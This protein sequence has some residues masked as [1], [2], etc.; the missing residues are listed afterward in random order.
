MI[1]YVL[2][3]VLDIS[4]KRII[5]VK[6]QKPDFLKGKINLV[7]GK[8]EKDESPYDAAIREL[9][10]ETGII[11][12][13]DFPVYMGILYG[14]NYKIYCYN[15]FAN[16]NIEPAIDELEI[17]YWDYFH[18]IRYSPDLIENLKIIIPMIQLGIVGWYIKDNNDGKY[19]IEFKN[20]GVN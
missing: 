6:K 19:I 12:E 16:D 4:T 17:P 8:I 2:I 5:V 14:E 18:N 15:M 20:K 10:E 7:G 9:K 13:Y 3:H 1:E 11:A